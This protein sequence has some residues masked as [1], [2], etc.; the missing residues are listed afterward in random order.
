MSKYIQVGLVAVA[1]ADLQKLSPQEK[2]NVIDNMFGGV[3]IEKDNQGQIV[4]YTDM[5]HD[6]EGMVVPFAIEPNETEVD[7]PDPYEHEEEELEVN[8]SE[9]EEVPDTLRM[10]NFPIA[11]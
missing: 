4:L 2:F 5:M 9:I 6:K 7:T 11:S 8:S 10:V 1:I 3:G